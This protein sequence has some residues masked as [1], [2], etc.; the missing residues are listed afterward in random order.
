MSWL[1]SAST[2]EAEAGNREA[3]R[4]ASR[5]PVVALRVALAFVFAHEPRVGVSHVDLFVGLRRGRGRLRLGVFGAAFAAGARGHFALVCAA[6]A[7]GAG[8]GAR[9]ELRAGGVHFPKQLFA[10]GDFRRELLRVRILAVA[11]LGLREQFAHV[12]PQLCAQL[13]RA[14]VGD[15][16]VLGGAGFEVRAVQ[17][18][19]AQ[20]EQLQ[21]ARQFQHIDK[22]AGHRLQVVAPESADRVVIGMRVG[23]QVAHGHVAVGGPL[24]APA[25]EEAVGV[26][27]DEQRE[28]QVRRELL[29][30]AA[31]VIDRE[32]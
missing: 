10:P 21:L 28:H 19:A 17:A 13:A 29:V 16:L 1:P 32:G 14:G 4:R 20:L 27:V 11:R 24:N 30:A 23:A 12:E 9:F 26:A 3:G 31:L 22:R 7:R 5:L 2:T 15:V 6:L 18:H 8:L 25:A